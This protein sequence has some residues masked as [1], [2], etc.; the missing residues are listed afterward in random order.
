MA[1]LLQYIEE[2]LFRRGAAHVIYG[3]IQKIPPVRV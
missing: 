1:E 3:I 2:L